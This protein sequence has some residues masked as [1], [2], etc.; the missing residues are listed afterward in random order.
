MAWPTHR[1]Q[2]SIIL[3][4]L[5]VLLCPATAEA[6]KKGIDPETHVIHESDLLEPRS[7]GGTPQTHIYVNPYDK[8]LV[9]P[10]FGVRGVSGNCVAAEPSKCSGTQ[11]PGST[12]Q[13]CHGSLGIPSCIW[14]GG[15][16]S[17]LLVKSCYAAYF[18]PAEYCG[19]LRGGRH[20][21]PG[22]WYVY[23]SELKHSQRPASS[24]NWR[25]SEIVTFG[26]ENRQGCVQKKPYQ[27]GAFTRS[28]IA[29]PNLNFAQAS[30]IVQAQ[31]KRC[32]AAL[33]KSG[34]K[35]ESR[36]RGWQ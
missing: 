14:S 26:V 9:P 13:C 35:C 21:T 28:I 12:C 16:T 33:G 3:F 2:L 29:G 32:C 5:A 20:D 27:K 25:D 23:R 17:L 6:K 10:D 31:G 34:T 15:S 8:G 30:E 19:A 18:S 11:R 22:P 24:L 7:G 1:K 36:S 4:A